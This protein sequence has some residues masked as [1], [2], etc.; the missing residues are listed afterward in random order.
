MKTDLQPNFTFLAVVCFYRL[1]VSSQHRSV[2]RGLWE[3]YSVTWLSLSAVSQTPVSLIKRKGI[4]RQWFKII[5]V[6]VSQM[7]TNRPWIYQMLFRTLVT[8]MFYLTVVSKYHFIGLIFLSTLRDDCIV[9]EDN[10]HARSS[11]WSRVNNISVLY[12]SD[13]ALPQNDTDTQ[14]HTHTRARTRAR[15][16]FFLGASQLTWAF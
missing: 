1:L 11:L 16:H 2:G 5:H 15:A 9:I 10:P 13:L 14:T 4:L 7:P 12:S 8:G 3:V 6:D